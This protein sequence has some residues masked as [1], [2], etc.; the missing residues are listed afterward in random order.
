MSVATEIL[1]RAIVSDDNR[2][3][4]ARERGNSWVFLPGG[5]VEPGEPIEAAL[6]RELAE[7]LGTTSRIVGFAGVVEHRYT[8]NGTAHHEINLIFNTELDGTPES[9][10]EHLEFVWL[11]IHQLHATDLRPRALKDVVAS[12]AR[13]VWYPWNG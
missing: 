7:E 3:L 2:L 9:Q 5:H 11:P 8:D 10:E 12:A 4:V 1:T 6:V 13:S